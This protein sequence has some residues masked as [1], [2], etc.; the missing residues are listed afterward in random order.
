MWT[1][2]FT[3]SKY[4]GLLVNQVPILPGVLHVLK[5]EYLTGFPGV[6]QWL[7][8]SETTLFTSLPSTS[9]CDFHSSITS[10]AFCMVG[11]IIAQKHTCHFSL[12]FPWCPSQRDTLW[13]MGKEVHTN[14]Y[15]KSVWFLVCFWIFLFVFNYIEGEFNWTVIWQNIKSNFWW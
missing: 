6:E 4:C 5:W 3:T 13:A 14:D 10:L 9:S 11:A 8:D 1:L 12:V 15:N 7:T 2:L